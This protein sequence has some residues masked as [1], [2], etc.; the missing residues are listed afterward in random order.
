MKYLLILTAIFLFFACVPACTKQTGI[1]THHYSAEIF[2]E[3]D[4]TI[5]VTG[6]YCQTDTISMDS[7]IG[8]VYND[9]QSNWNYSAGSL[10]V[11]K[12]ENGWQYFAIIKKQI[13]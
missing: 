10:V 9:T 8:I 1:V 5:K 11:L 4:S 12:L 13:D 3:L 2:R 7:V 6:E